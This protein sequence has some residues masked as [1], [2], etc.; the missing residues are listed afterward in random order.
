MR[1]RWF[2]EYAAHGRNTQM[3]ACATEHLGDFDLAH[4]GTQYLE[5]L[6]RVAH[7]LRKAVHRL[8]KL[9]KRVG[10]VL[11]DTLQPGGDGGIGDEKLLCRLS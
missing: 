6:Y 8:A 2:L 3:E 7:E 10:P 11:V 5:T 4:A 1:T 9:H